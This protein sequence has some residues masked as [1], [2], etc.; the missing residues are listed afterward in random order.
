MFWEVGWMVIPK[1]MPDEI[2]DGVLKYAGRMTY[3]S[4]FKEVYAEEFDTYRSQ[5]LFPEKKIPKV[6]ANMIKKVKTDLI[7]PANMKWNAK[8][9]VALKSI[10]GGEE[11]DP[12][13]DFPSMEIGEARIVEKSCQ[14]GLI[15]GLMSDTK[16]IVYKKCFA[17]VD[18]SKR[19]ELKF[20]RGDLIVFRGD[21]AH[22]GAAY[23]TTNYRVHAALT[24]GDL[25]WD[26]NAT[27]SA[28]VKVFK[29]KFCPFKENTNR[30]V[31]NHMRNC[32][33]NPRREELQL[34]FRKNLEKTRQC[35]I[36]FK[37][38]KKVSFSNHMRRKHPKK[39]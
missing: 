27:E 15:L 7:Q 33:F 12:H 10:K 25:E 28:P 31:H 8:K 13:R 36:C 5:A 23:D 32:K 29:C 26:D 1:F 18:I 38:F 19:V 2:V 16:L 21:L 17:E 22:A 30:K 11:Q 37:T 35:E 14:A 3:K 6:V 24:V 39:S 4:I 9:W 34:Q 20:G